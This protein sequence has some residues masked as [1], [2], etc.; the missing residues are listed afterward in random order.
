MDS[1]TPNVFLPV[2][3][4]HRS[5]LYKETIDLYINNATVVHQMPLKVHF[6]GEQGVDTGGL[7]R[8]LFSAFWE[9]AY[10][11]LFE[12][13]S[14]LVPAVH[15]HIDMQTLP[16]LGKIISHGYLSCGYLPVRIAFPTLAT[17]LL[18][19]ATEVPPRLLLQAF[20][21]YLTPLDRATI[22]EATKVQGVLFG[23]AVATKLVSILSR[24]G[25]RQVP[26]PHTLSNLLVQVAR[27]E[28][29]SRPF[30]AITLMNSGI[31]PEHSLSLSELHALYI[32]LN[33]SVQKVLELIDEPVFTHPSQE[34]IFGYLREYVANLKADEVQN[35]LRFVTG[36]GV[37]M[38]SRITVSFNALSG[39]ARRPI[40][41]TCGCQLELSTAYTTYLDFASEFTAVLADECC[42]EMQSI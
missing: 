30:A 6:H 37:C 25:C 38:N 21:D 36:S 39:L 5:S 31:P 19:P 20:R 26:S 11:E 33:A 18:G 8:D 28:F 4:V 35:F 29:I 41:H 1:Y 12:G 42:W 16:V 27:H 14:L 34:R 10:R 32:A 40:S 22:R 9:I 23:N 15:A 17:V 2:V 3:K 24:F 13:C 7:G